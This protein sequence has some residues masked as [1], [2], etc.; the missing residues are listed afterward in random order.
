LA[1][2]LEKSGFHNSWGLPYRGYTRSGNYPIGQGV[3]HQAV[4]QSLTQSTWP[5]DAPKDFLTRTASLNGEDDVPYTFYSPFSEFRNQGQAGE[6]QNTYSHW[7]GF[8]SLANNLYRSWATPPDGGSKVYVYQAQWRGFSP[9]ALYSR[10]HALRSP[11]SVRAASGRRI[12]GVYPVG[13]LGGATGD[14]E[15]LLTGPRRTHVFAV[16]ESVD[17][18]GGEAL[19]EADTQ[20]GIVV[21]PDVTNIDTG[22]IDASKGGTSPTFISYPSAPFWDSYEDFNEDLKL[23]GKDYSVIPEFRIS[24][25]VEDYNKFGIFNPNKFDT[26]EIFGSKAANGSRITS[27]TSSFYNDYSNSEFLKDFLKVKADSLLD[28]KEIKLTCN[29]VVRFNPYKG[30]YPAQR[31]LDL[32]SQFS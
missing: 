30:F 4:V 6:L 32:V 12:A 11:F 22:D 24:E 9:S 15:P 20:A 2:G 23:V 19:W 17:E 1:N 8:G 3:W 7:L 26:F 29:A 31:T 5:L 10:K 13:N 25:H 28:A 21:R 16:A 18:G 14:I 27:A